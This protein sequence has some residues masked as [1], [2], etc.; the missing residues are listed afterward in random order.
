MSTQSKAVAAANLVIGFAQTMETLRSQI[1]EF[2]VEYNSE[3][4][5]AMWAAFATAAQNPD[6]TLGAADGTPVTSHPI[7]TGNI[8]RS[9]QALVNGVSLLQ[10]FQ[11]FLTNQPVTTKQRSQTIDDLVS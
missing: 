4:Y 8:S 11:A 5:S 1:N 3:G 10:D 6:G 9:Q 7:T 2:V